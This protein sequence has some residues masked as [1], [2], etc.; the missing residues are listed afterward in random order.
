MY[1]S[2]LPSYFISAKPPQL[3]SS[4]V[5]HRTASLCFSVEQ[6][7]SP[8]I[9]KFLTTYSMPLQ[10]FLWLLSPLFLH[11]SKC[12]PRI[13]IYSA[14]L[15]FQLNCLILHVHKISSVPHHTQRTAKVNLNPDHLLQH[16]HR[17]TQHGYLTTWI[18]SSI[19]QPLTI[20]LSLFHIHNL[21]F[22]II[23]TAILTKW[24]VYLQIHATHLYSSVPS[25]FS[26]T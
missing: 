5:L 17:I 10:L 24:L 14:F 8:A 18:T 7:C 9:Y 26:L 16:H 2:I 4:I 6:L 11:C 13:K 1:L 21:P 15:L 12:L 23:Q 19:Y 3:C 22:S 20:I 25:V